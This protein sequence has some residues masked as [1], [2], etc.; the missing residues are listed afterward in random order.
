MHCT[1]FFHF[2]KNNCY[3]HPL[4]AD[5]SKF[6]ISNVCEAQHSFFLLLYNSALLL[7]WIMLE[8]CVCL[9]HPC[10]MAV[11]VYILFYIKFKF[12]AE[13]YLSAQS[14]WFRTYIRQ[15]FCTKTACYHNSFL[16]CAINLINQHR[17]CP[18]PHLPYLSL[19]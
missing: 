5:I 17:L 19:S 3:W 11:M 18:P 8:L 15:T 2:T 9:S 10:F 16:Q 7:K 1:S 12:W 14:N 6:S 4:H 13:K